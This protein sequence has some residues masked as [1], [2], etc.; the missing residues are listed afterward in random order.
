ML[1]T[2]GEREIDQAGVLAAFEVP[3]DFV[4]GAVIALGYQ[5]EPAELGQEHMIAME[6]APRQR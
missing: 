2:L 5:G 4:A 1:A 3:S 6:E